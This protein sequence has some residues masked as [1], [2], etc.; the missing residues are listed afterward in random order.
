MTV[1]HFL[2]YSGSVNLEIHRNKIKSDS[3]F[4]FDVINGA[5]EGKFEN[6]TVTVLAKGFVI[7]DVTYVSQDIP[8][9]AT[10]YD[11]YMRLGDEFK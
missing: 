9:D 11:D 6:G 2:C 1:R 3:E 10:D 7:N 4:Y 8:D 5:W